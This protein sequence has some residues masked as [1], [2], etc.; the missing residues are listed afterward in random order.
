MFCKDLRVYMSSAFPRCTS[1]TVEPIIV[2]HTHICI[3]STLGKGKM[4]FCES[5]SGD[6]HCS[7][8]DEFCT[9]LGFLPFLILLQ[10]FYQLLSWSSPCFHFSPTSICLYLSMFKTMFQNSQV[11]SPL[12]LQ[13]D[14]HPLVS[15][16]FTRATCEPSN[17]FPELIIFWS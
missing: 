16:V 4:I 3:V 7:G 6:V 12:C 2:L 15:C 13:C 9:Q 10:D 8:L 5:Q 11:G 1:I 17:S 14:L